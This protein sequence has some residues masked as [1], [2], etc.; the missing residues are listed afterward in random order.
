MI[1]QAVLATSVKMAT[2]WDVGAAFRSN[3][4]GDE[5]SEHLWNVG[6]FAPYYTVQY[7][8]RQPRSYQVNFCVVFVVITQG[9]WRYLLTLVSPLVRLVF[10]APG[11]TGTPLIP[12][13]MARHGAVFGPLTTLWWRSETHRIPLIPCRSANDVTATWYVTLELSREWKYYTRG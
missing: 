7:P 11:S 3:C 13:G 4:P 12:A 2:F 10:M 6:Q 8:G 5:G 9:G 1:L